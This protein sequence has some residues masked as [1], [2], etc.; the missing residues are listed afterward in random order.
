M[1][2]SAPRRQAAATKRVAGPPPAVPRRLRRRVAAA[3]GPPPPPGPLTAESP[4]RQ[5]RRRRRRPGASLA[6]AV[7]ADTV[8][9]AAPTCSWAGRVQRQLRLL[10]RRQNGAASG[11]PQPAGLLAWAVAQPP[12]SPPSGPPGADTA[13]ALS[14]ALWGGGWSHHPGRRRR[15]Q[16]RSRAVPAAGVAPPSSLPAA[17]ACPAARGSRTPPAI[18]FL[19][20]CIECIPCNLKSVVKPR[21]YLVSR[22]TLI[23]EFACHGLLESTTPKLSL[24]GDTLIR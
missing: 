6:G 15:R 10:W 9:A 14:G 1:L 19:S 3:A 5:R 24:L 20:G 11:P 18:D 8:T 22:I 13:A 17:L 12:R 23:L 7:D 4:A 21:F 16:W 2:G